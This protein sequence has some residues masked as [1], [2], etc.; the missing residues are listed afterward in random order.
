MSK[1]IDLNKL[2]LI[3]LITLNMQIKPISVPNSISILV[4]IK[5]GITIKKIFFEIVSY[6]QVF[7][8]VYSLVILEKTTSTT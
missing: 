1:L 6:S 3:M 8:H 5:G 2:D 7:Q 4:E